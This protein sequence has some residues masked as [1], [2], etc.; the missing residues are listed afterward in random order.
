MRDRAGLWQV[1][2]NRS[3]LFAASI[4]PMMV[5][6]SAAHATSLG[7][8]N[9]ITDDP[10]GHPA[11]LTDPDLQNAWGVSFAPPGP[12]WVSDNG[13]AVTTLYSVNPVTDVPAKV[14]ALPKVSI[15]G[16]GTV[17]GQTFN[18]GFSGGSFNGDLFLFVS[19]DG[20]ISGWRFSL[21]TAAETLQTGS[22]ANVYKG[23]T[24]ADI[25][26][27]DYLYAANFRSGAI[28]VL[29]GNSGEPNLTG[30][31]SDPTLPGGYAPFNIQNLGGKLF[32]TYAIQDGAKHDEVPGLGNGIVDEFDTNG[33]LINRIATGGN[34]DAPWGLAIAPSSFGTLAG[35]LLVGNFGNGT[36]DVIDLATNTP[37]ELL[38]DSRGK[39]I[40]IDG[41]WALTVGNDT[42]A[43]SSNKVYFSAGP[44]EE[45]H[46]LFG[47]IE[48][49]PEPSTWMELLAGF[50]A[51][52]AAVR[53]LGHRLQRAL[54]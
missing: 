42:I 12:F 18:P 2:N 32:V 39:T 17:T 10:I 47:V 14:L 7:V 21:G 48:P 31:F 3:T 44:D 41:L 51:M 38:T 35:D 25:T 50:A 20:T 8:V 52:A 22:T 24:F 11:K 27:N 29:K 40:T 45:S 23:A 6:G 37:V 46:G 54:V 49:V 13:K 34:L 30:T 16:D 4:L 28:D 15:P 33:N 5:F 43:G 26:G 9:L 1:F 53:L 36:I 19:E